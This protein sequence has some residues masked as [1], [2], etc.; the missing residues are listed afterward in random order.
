MPMTTNEVAPAT[1]GEVLHT[2]EPIAAGVYVYEG[3]ALGRRPD[4]IL[5]PFEGGDVFAG[6]AMSEFRAGGSD[7]GASL[8]GTLSNAGRERVRVLAAADRVVLPIFG[9][10]SRGDIGAPVFALD[11]ETFGLVGHPDGKVGRVLDIESSSRALVEM[12]TPGAWLPSDCVRA[13][14]VDYSTDW[15]RPFGTVT[16]ASTTAT[17][18]ATRW[19]VRA[20]AA[21]GSPTFAHVDGLPGYGRLLFTSAN[22]AQYLA[23]Q[24]GLNAALA[25]GV[26][27]EF[28]ARIA[29]NGTSASDFDIG[30][31]SFSSTL[32][33][34]QLAD[35]PAASG[36]RCLLAHLDEDNAWRAIVDDNATAG[37]TYSTGLSNSVSAYTQGKLILRPSGAGELWLNP[38]GTWARVLA[39]T[40]LSVGSSAAYFG[41]VVNLEK[42]TA[43][44]ATEARLGR[45]RF[46]GAYSA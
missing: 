38:S 30:L 32:G 28:S 27:A 20:Q 23:I 14:V 39:L 40:P 41:L 33:D 5:K 24:S 10:L 37:L 46:A 4:G 18:F 36:L 16:G 6:F 13:N 11:D 35:L 3:A 15:S 17:N 7:G 43:T 1:S 29:T 31:F 2:D 9:T 25:F 12:S 21:S 34:T 45:L 44:D 8:T 26:T 42:T 19:N 22:A